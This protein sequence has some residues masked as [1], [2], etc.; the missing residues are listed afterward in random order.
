MSLALNATVTRVAMKSK[1]S[2]RIRLVQVFLGAM[3]LIA[4]VMVRGTN[5]Q[6]E[7]AHL[8]T[9]WSHRH[10]VFSEPIETN[11]ASMP[12]DKRVSRRRR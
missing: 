3:L 6:R 4:L 9:D 10:V 8:V 7:H 11:T 5:A 1:H 2:R 12:T